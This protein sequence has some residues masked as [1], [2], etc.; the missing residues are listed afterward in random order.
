VSDAHERTELPTPRRLAKARAEG[1]WPSSAL[2]GGWLA[3]VLIALPVTV[4]VATGV[5]WV[6][7][8]RFTA[9]RAGAI[10]AGTRGPELLEVLAAWCSWKDAWAVVA[11]A[12]AAA[13]IAAIGAAAAGGSLAFAPASLRPRLDRLAWGAGLKHLLNPDGIAQTILAL[14]CFA[15]T[16]WCTWLAAN[17]LQRISAADLAPN[18]MIIA[19]ADAMR[20]AWWGL[21]LALAAPA[22]F[23]VWRTR[24]RGGTALRMTPREVR[25]ERADAEGK[26]ELRARR[27]AYAAGGMRNV[28]IGAIR[29]ATAVVTN[30]THVAVA[31]RYAPPMIEVPIV[32]S[33]GADLAAT[34]VR[35]IAAA[36]DVP[37][38][39]SP[40]LARTLYASAALGEPIPE[41]VYAD[42]AAVFA[43][44][45]RTRGTLGGADDP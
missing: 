4:A 16:L 36:H 33:R 28:K 44:L 14:V 35:A 12:A 38:I 24:R 17:A 13:L 1:R 26:P 9:S 39:E 2:A 11:A 27:R 25:E 19:V 10:A 30:P 43:W 31:L 23:D 6:A 3:I 37:V 5:H 32:V 20:D 8:W 18:G 22:C 29:R 21:V 45:L 34:L 7:L 41:E 40:E 42:V 15:L